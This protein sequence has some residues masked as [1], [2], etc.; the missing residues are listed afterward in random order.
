MCFRPSAMIGEEPQVQ[1]GTCPSCGMPVAASI[2]IKSGKC[3][4]CDKPIPLDSEDPAGG[5]SA[6]KPS[7]IL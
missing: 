1:K 3:P 7:K 5:A 2:G 6:A 4:H